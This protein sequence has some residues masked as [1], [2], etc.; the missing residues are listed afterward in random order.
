MEIIVVALKT[1]GYK[2]KKKRQQYSTARYIQ[3]T[4]QQ[5]QHNLT[6]DENKNNKTIKTKQ[7]MES[8]NGMRVEKSTKCKQ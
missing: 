5:I 7:N 3:H 6:K 8:T 1:P 2:C 4:I